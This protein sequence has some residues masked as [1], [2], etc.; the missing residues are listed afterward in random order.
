MVWESG[1]SVHFCN[2]YWGNVMKK[3]YSDVQAT[4]RRKFWKPTDLR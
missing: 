3:E 1:A 2:Q 4:T